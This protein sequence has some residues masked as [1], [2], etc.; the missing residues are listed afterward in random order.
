MMLKEVYH[1]KP[2][3]EI[4]V[5]SEEELNQAINDVCEKIFQTD[6]LTE[7]KDG[8]VQIYDLLNPRIKWTESIHSLVS[9]LI[10]DRQFFVECLD[11]IYIIV[12]E[13]VQT[14]VY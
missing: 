8:Y 14:E 1:F 12:V 11:D 10:D 13:K 5:L 7:I 3:F 6:I 2:S 4:Y 9:Y